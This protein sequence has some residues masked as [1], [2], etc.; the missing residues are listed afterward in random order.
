MTLHT[1]RLGR[2]GLDVTEIGLGCYMFTGEFGVPQ[3]EAEAI[4]DLALTSGVN[5]IDTAQM[6]GFGEGEELVGRALQRH[7]GSAIH[8]S[9]K[10][11]WLD[12][13]VVRN[14]GDEAYRNEEALTRTIKHSLWLLRRD[15]VEILMV[16]EP[17]WDRWGL[18][19]KTGDAPIM[20]VLESL[21]SEGVIGAIG[22]GGWNCDT[23]A[24]LIETGRFD[25]ALVAGGY[26]LVDQPVR[27]RVL[28]TAAAHDVGLIMGGTFL[29]GLLAVQQRE[30]MEQVQRLG[31]YGGRLTPTAVK[32]ILAVYDLCDSTGISVTEM[33]I[34][35][36]LNDPG[37][38][39]IIPG[40][41]KVQHLRENLAAAAKGPL[42][43]DLTARIEAIAG[44]DAPPDEV[45]ACSDSISPA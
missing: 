32:R 14:L 38:H 44:L 6:Y 1:R 11:G 20:N 10:V 33:A 37:I 15:H 2:T 27:T 16:H 9:S 26:T 31:N 42:P 34:R 18:D 19:P 24:D 36:I 4:L 17:D 40:A 3:S 22:M 41:Q 25:C 7:R 43:E 39:T 29:Q 8:V 35:F 28:A 23:I 13:T 30:R 21:K 5:Y 45:A 12:R